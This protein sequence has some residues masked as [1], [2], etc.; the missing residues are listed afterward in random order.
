MGCISSN[1]KEDAKDTV[2]GSVVGE[3]IARPLVGDILDANL[4]IEFEVSMGR[5]K[6]VC[7]SISSDSEQNEEE[8]NVSNRNKILWTNVDVINDSRQVDRSYSGVPIVYI[9]N[10]EHASPR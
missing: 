1:I 7:T 8:T 6:C 2:L 10:I 5:M 4:E 9:S 3:G